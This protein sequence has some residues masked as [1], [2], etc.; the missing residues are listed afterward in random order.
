MTNVARHVL[1][2][3]CTD[4]GKVAAVKTGLLD[5]LKKLI[6]IH[7]GGHLVELIVD[8]LSSLLESGQHTVPMHLSSYIIST[9]A[10]V[11]FSYQFIYL[12]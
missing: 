3:L 8:L 6:D 7:S 2:F 11:Q 4:E 9:D 1:S 10:F 12:S 5:T